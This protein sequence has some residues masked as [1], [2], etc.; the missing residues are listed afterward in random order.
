VTPINS[1]KSVE[2]DEKIYDLDRF[3]SGQLDDR[4]VSRD[5][6]EDI[7]QAL[8]RTEA[9]A[10]EYTAQGRPDHVREYEGQAHELRKLAEFTARNVFRIYALFSEAFAHAVNGGHWHIAQAHLIDAIKAIR[11]ATLTGV[12]CPN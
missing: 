9:R 7:E 11:V 2:V 1:P 6:V 3:T 8:A 12:G 4:E 5:C 10:A